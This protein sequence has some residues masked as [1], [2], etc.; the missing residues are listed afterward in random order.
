MENYE[1]RY[2]RIRARFFI[3]IHPGLSPFVL[4][5]SLPANQH[6]SHVFLGADRHAR[7]RGQCDVE[8]A[9]GVL[10]RF[11][12]GFGRHS[13]ERFG[14]RRPDRGENLPARAVFDFLRVSGGVLLPLEQERQRSDARVE[15][16][17]KTPV[18]AGR[19]QGA[20]EDAEEMCQ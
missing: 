6:V 19:L 4:L 3:E 13:F 17:E 1:S 20:Q 18:A 5:G 7:V 11:P 8:S 9:G 10:L 12:L 16:A 2:N 15:F 14:V